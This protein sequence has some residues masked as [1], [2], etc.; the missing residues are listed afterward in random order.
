MNLYLLSQQ[1]SI[2]YDTYDAC[3]VAA[4]TEDEARLI[5][6]DKYATAATSW[7]APKDIVV[8]L[9]GKAA[10]G[11]QSGVILASYNAG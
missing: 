11:T 4:G 2:D 10:K 6:P 5:L 9:I 7:A 8:K 1:V 3:V